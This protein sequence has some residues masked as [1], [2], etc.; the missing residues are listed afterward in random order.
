MSLLLS[1]CIAEGTLAARP[2]ASIDGRLYFSTDAHKIYRDN[3]L[4]WDDVTPGAPAA[5]LNAAPTAAGNFSIAHG[6]SAA[7]SRIEI[8][9]T[10]AGSI[11]QQAAPD[12]TNVNLS[13]SDAGITA[14]IF[15][16][17]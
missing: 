2:A 6:L 13:S 12:A 9:P 5:A 4:T 10:S 1:T 8:L 11:W 15:V 7:P 14:I 16:F 17:A 3:G